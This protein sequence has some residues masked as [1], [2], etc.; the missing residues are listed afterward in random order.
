MTYRK[1][2]SSEQGQ[3]T[4]LGSVSQ[5]NFWLNEALP[6]PA[7]MALSRGMNGIA[8]S[9]DVQWARYLASNSR[10]GKTQLIHPVLVY[11]PGRS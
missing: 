11:T 4:I 10:K 6:P 3:E 8:V 5:V 9:G 2:S 7:L 1:P